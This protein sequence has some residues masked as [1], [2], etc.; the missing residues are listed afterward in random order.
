MH[1]SVLIREGLAFAV[2][3]MEISFDRPAHI[4]DLVD[5]ETSIAS[6]TGARMHIEQI[7]RRDGEV[8]VSAKA[9]I[10]M[11]DHAGRPVRLPKT[12]VS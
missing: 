9:E 8:L 1:H 6:V 2:R 12:L 4:D 3:R 10:V 11:I 5:I 7:M